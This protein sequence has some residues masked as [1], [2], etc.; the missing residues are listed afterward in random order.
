MGS[1]P[2]QEMK[3]AQAEEQLSP[4]PET[5]KPAPLHNQRAHV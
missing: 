2:G 3:I 4:C 5:T 1:I